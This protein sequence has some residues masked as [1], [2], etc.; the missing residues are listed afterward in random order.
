LKMKL[1]PTLML[2]FSNFENPFE[3]HT[4]ANCNRP[5]YARKTPNSLWK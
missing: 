5:L 1:S 2:W 4:N 3:M